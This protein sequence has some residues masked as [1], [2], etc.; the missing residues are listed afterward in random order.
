MHLLVISH[1]PVSMM[2]VRR[3]SIKRNSIKR[4]HI[5]ENNAR[6]PYSVLRFA[7]CRA[8][9]EPWATPASLRKEAL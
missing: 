5:A 8:R 1:D 7:E 2:P 6:K 3:N 9:W 4:A